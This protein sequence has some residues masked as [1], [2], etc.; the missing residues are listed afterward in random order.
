LPEH[1][2]LLWSASKCYFTC[3]EIW[4]FFKNFKAT[5]VSRVLHRPWTWLNK[6]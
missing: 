6:S 5:T 1:L 3:H 2:P 4:F